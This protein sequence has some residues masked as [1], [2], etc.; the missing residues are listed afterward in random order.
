MAA[1]VDGHIALANDESDNDRRGYGFT[2]EADHQHLR[3][4]IS[5][6]DAI[7]AGANTV[8]VSSKLIDCQNQQGRYPLWVCLT[9]R[10]IADDNPFWRTGGQRWLVSPR[11]TSTNADARYLS[12]GTNDPARFI[13]DRLRD[14]GAREVL[15]FGGGI[16]NRLFYQQK[17]VDE[18]ML[19]VCPLI[20][21][22]TAGPKLVAPPLTSWTS[23][24]LLTV[25][26][27]DNHLF[28]HYRV[29]GLPT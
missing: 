6:C 20:V 17:L 7:I 3:Q 12:Y 1:S 16:V 28:L 21:A 15:L 5:S 25:R 26:Q 24:R 10:G 8:R 4:V 18:L 19:T 9:T 22:R 11:Q 29:T 23:L 14:H 13:V 2:S 27:V